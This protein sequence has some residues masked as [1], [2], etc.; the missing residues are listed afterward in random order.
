MSWKRI[1]PKAI[2]SI[3]LFGSR[4][5][6]HE[7]KPFSESSL[8]FVTFNSWYD[9]YHNLSIKEYQPMNVH[10]AISKHT[11]KMHAHLEV[12]QSLDQQREQAIELAAAECLAGRSY[13]VDGINRITASINE[14]AKHG[15]SPTRPYITEEMLIT[16]VNQLKVL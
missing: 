6:D 16:Y 8:L 4:D 5:D 9:I 11:R 2:L 10:E 15:I 3:W 7:Y 1:F 12:F 13:S 14:H